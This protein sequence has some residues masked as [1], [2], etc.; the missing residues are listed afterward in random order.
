MPEALI[1]ERSTTAVRESGLVLVV[2]DDET[3]RALVKLHL[4]R[5]GYAVLV[6]ADALQGGKLAA[7]TSPSLVICDLEMPHLDGYRFALSLKS[8]PR[9]RHIPLVFL[10][11]NDDVAEKAAGAG[12]LGHLEKP[13]TGERLL[14]MVRRF[15]SPSLRSLGE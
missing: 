8:D 11:A 9:T 4:V 13:V 14:Q 10:S 15:V 2:D 1:A 7:A 5:A 3:M 12:A 6:A